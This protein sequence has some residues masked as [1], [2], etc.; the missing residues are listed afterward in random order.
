VKIPNCIVSCKECHKCHD[1]RETKVSKPRGFVSNYGVDTAAQG[2]ICV[3]TV[4]KYECS[5]YF[6]LHFLRGGLSGV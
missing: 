6:F 3:R 4:A 2:S 1:W 5:E